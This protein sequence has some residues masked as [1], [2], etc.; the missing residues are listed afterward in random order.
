MPYTF[1][2]WRQRLAERSDVSTS[3]THLTRGPD[4]KEADPDAALEVLL[5]IIVDK[6][7][8]GSTTAS[9]FI[10]GNRPAVCFQEAPP[11]FLAQNVYFEKKYRK[12][13]I[14]AKV[15][16]LGFGLIFNKTYAFKKGCRPV[17]YDRT[18]DAKE[19]L[20]KVEWW[21]IVNLNLDADDKLV[22]WT[23]EREWRCPD[24][25]RFERNRATILLPNKSAYRRFV[26]RSREIET[27]DGHDLLAEIRGFIDM[28]ALL[29]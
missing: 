7:I 18:S 13:D 6:K 10:C 19:Y 28:H 1:E 16:Y 3:I 23:H 4:G 20:P 29:Y 12:V 14:A 25:F 2:S 26:E 15:R 8:R 5:K 9:G 11:Q 17:I 24:N 21:R 27:A 22:D